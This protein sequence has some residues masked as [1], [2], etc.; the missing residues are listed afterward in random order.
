M[1]NTPAP[2]EPGPRSEQGPTPGGGGAVAPGQHFLR[3]GGPTPEGPPD[4]DPIPELRRRPGVQLTPGEQDACAPLVCL[5]FSSPVVGLEVGPPSTLTAVALT[6]PEKS[7]L[8]ILAEFV[9]R[10]ETSVR[11]RV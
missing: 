6:H 3:V 11:L 7:W 10:E 9:A 5:D 2:R 1:Q 8:E 4:S